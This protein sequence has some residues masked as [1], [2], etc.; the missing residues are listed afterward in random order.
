LLLVAA[1]AAA[2]V[3]AGAARTDRAPGLRAA[4][5]APRATAG[6]SRVH[7]VPR[8]APPRTESRGNDAPPSPAQI[9]RAYYAALDAHQFAR[10]WARL[11]PAVR[12]R[13]G[14][15]AAWRAGYGTTL[16]HTVVAIE[17]EAN[18]VVQVTLTATDRT[19]CGGTTTRQFAVIWR[20]DAGRATALS[21]TKLA[22]QDPVAAC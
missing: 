4:D 19:P 11:T 5:V 18:G 13:F 15:F 6:M 9:V 10:A 21:A 12:A 20:L 3:A 8:H 14:G 1:V 16:G 7:A 17:T 22:G 2:V